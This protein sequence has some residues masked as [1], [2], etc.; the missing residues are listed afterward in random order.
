MRNSELSKRQRECLE[1]RR[2]HKT[3]KEIGRELNI[4]H[5]TVVMHWR[6]A[7]LKLRPIED[8][9]PDRDRRT[10]AYD[11]PGLSSP[12]R[13][14]RRDW[15]SIFAGAAL[16]LSILMALL[17]IFALLSLIIVDHFSLRLNEPYYGIFD[18]HC[19]ASDCYGKSA[20]KRL[21]H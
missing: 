20:L 18:R 14:L 13:W 15:V 19:P 17:Y 1:G 7:R 12:W 16:I 4:S 6:L 5:N 11:V 21:I 2:Q 10:G 8:R 9:L 3:A